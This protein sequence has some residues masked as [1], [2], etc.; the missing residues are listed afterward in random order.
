L[1]GGFVASEPAEQL[2]N[3]L[4]IMHEEAVEA[5]RPELGYHLLAAA[6]HA[7]EELD[8]LERLAEIRH[9]AEDRQKKLDSARPEHRLSS[10]A[11][12]RRGNP[13]Q[14]TALAA[15]AAAASGRISADRTLKRS[16]SIQAQRE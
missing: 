3:R 4:L 11:A 9:L 16:R 8:S 12:R 10:G 13:A 2:Y 5:S 6:L 14:Y 15:I 1:T 7:A